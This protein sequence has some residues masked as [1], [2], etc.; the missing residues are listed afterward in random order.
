MHCVQVAALEAS[1]LRERVAAQ[2]RE[3]DALRANL[4]QKDE[5]IREQAAAIEM[6]EER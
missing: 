6:L 3:V 2:D 5:E 4:R 1:Q